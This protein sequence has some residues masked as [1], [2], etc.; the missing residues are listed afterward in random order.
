MST[1]IKG[2]DAD[3]RVTLALNGSILAQEAVSVLPDDDATRLHEGIKVVER[4][5]YVEV[6]T[7]VMGDE[8]V[9]AR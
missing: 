8:P 7:R 6:L 4:R 3:G 1:P 2:N 5:L 9:A